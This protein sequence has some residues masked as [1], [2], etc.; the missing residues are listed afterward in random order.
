MIAPNWR[1]HDLPNGDRPHI[2]LCK[3]GICL[4]R[5]KA[6][7]GWIARTAGSLT[8]WL[9]GGAVALREATT[10]IPKPPDNPGWADL[11]QW[12]ASGSD[13]A[14]MIA[15][16]ASG[17]GLVASLYQ[18][19]GPKPYTLAQGRK[20]RTRQ[21]AS[22]AALDDREERRHATTYAKVDELAAQ[23][24]ILTAHLALTQPQQASAAEQAAEELLATGEASDR[25]IVE[26]F[27]GEYPLEA[28]DALMAEV[29]AGRHRNAERARQAARLYAPFSPGKAKEAYRQA[30]DLDPADFWSWIELGRLCAAYDG[31]AAARDCFDAA[32]RHVANQRDR[33]VVHVAFGSV[34]VAEGQLSMATEEYAAALSIAERLGAT[35]PD[36][37]RWQRDLSVIY[38]K[39]GDIEVT[40]GNLTRARQRFEE[41]LAIREKRAQMESGNAGWQRD[42]SVSYSK[43]GDLEVA[44]SNFAMAREW[45]EKVRVI[46]ETLCRTEPGNWELQRDLSVSYNK[47]GDVEVAAGNVAMA[48][49]RFE[50]DLE[51]ARTLAQAEPGNAGWQRDLSVSFERLGDLEI[52]TNNFAAARQQFEQ[53]LAI[54]EKIVLADPD[55]RGWQRDVSVIYERL[56]DVELAANELA[57][58]FQRFEQAK[59]IRDRLA[60]AEPGNSEW[61]RDLCVIHERLGLLATRAGKSDEALARYS[62]AEEIMVALATTWPD[63]PGF[64][65]D[66]SDI[67]LVLAELQAPTKS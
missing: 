34:L 7:V 14:A 9:G 47:L 10:S 33:M 29:Q 66:L 12:I 32:L 45:F 19:F 48:R 50:Q 62:Q 8:V 6:W 63:H 43:L 41:A 58:A 11:A 51:I 25:A 3:G 20:D 18:I 27:V 26:S 36:N 30:V 16:L 56:G 42:L 54:R 28:G 59:D 39:L 65:K 60:A 55:N 53:A 37:A 67:R 31:L 2:L 13:P 4:L 52:E 22:F 61:Q 57:V 40:A 24:A 38:N 21:D 64:A 15:A 23:V 17:L 49:T 44:E 46:R 35:E 5:G 1:C